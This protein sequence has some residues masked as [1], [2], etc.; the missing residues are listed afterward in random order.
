VQR[1]LIIYTGSF[2]FPTGDA[3][4]ARVLGIGKSL[5]ELG[6]EVVFGGGEAEG[7]VEDR[8]EPAGYCYQGFAYVPQG[9]LERKHS[10]PFRR[11][12]HMV[13]TTKNTLRWI[14]GYRS[15]GIAAIMA[16]GPSA[17]LQT[18]LARFTRRHGIPSILDLTEWR[19]GSTLPGGTF[20]PRNLESEFCMRYLYRR[21][22]SVIAI[23]SYLSDYYR[24]PTC[25]VIRI[26]PLVDL[27][28]AKWKMPAGNETGSLRLI[29]AGTPGNKDLLGNM[30][31]GVL[32][33]RGSARD[34]ELHLVGVT[35]EE[36]GRLCG[37]TL[38]PP[39][40]GSAK[41]ICHGRVAQNEVP[42]MLSR[43]DFSVLLRPDNKNARAGFATKLVESLSAGT[44]V[45]VNVTSDVTEYVRDGREGFI[46]R[47]N[48][49]EDLAAT[50]RIVAGL[51]KERV[52]E[53]RSL[54]KDR[55]RELFDYRSY[56]SA[57]K[58][59]LESVASDEIEPK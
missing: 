5:R 23:S 43:A 48:S 51:P 58:G 3:A 56:C 21:S 53:M 22:R 6:Y 29:Y 15:R 28:E 42:M 2:R 41:V 40:G 37:C 1:P 24:S 55:A 10:N 26:P 34:V 33:L 19:T 4:A 31:R 59:F 11:L 13:T 20:G 36:A 45:I 50:L 25:Q 7:R 47:G 9:G 39:E 54:A 57:L 14:E 44:P 49:P 38:T 27:D 12:A 46:V 35:E 32:L 52:L 17:L 8:V 18:H 30:I 16:Y